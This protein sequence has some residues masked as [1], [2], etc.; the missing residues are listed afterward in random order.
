[1]LRTISVRL[2][3]LVSDACFRSRKQQ[4]WRV[5][6]PP[7]RAGLLARP[8]RLTDE[9]LNVERRLAHAAR[10]VQVRIAKDLVA[11]CRALTVDANELEREVALGVAGYAPELLDLKGC[12]R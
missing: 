10:C 1:M 6:P 4:C 5:A 3:R 11:R 12:G 2:V 9:Q 7:G 8:L